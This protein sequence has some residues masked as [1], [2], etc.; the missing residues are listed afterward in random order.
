MLPEA[1]FPALRILRSN[2]SYTP[3]LEELLVLVKQ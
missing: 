3:K 1:V 2:E